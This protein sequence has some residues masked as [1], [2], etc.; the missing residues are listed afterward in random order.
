MELDE[1][2]LKI[3]A[4]L[5]ENGKMGYREM[6]QKLKTNPSTIFN[7]VRSLEAKGVIKRYTTIVDPDSLGYEIT[8]V[9]MI[10]ASG[11]RIVD[12]EKQ[13]A[14]MSE[15]SLVYDITGEFD[16]MVSAKF[17][18][19]SSLDK[20]VKKILTLEGVERTTTNLVLNVVKED[21]SLPIHADF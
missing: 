19:R 16:I 8:A 1:L 4:L 20:F 15:S 7:R 2:D 21:L 12:L 17:R 13:L 18:D 10:R 6:A 5:Q 11:P 9:I 3:L 14:S